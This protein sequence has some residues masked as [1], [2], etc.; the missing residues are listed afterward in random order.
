MF[1]PF[2][3]DP[4]QKVVRNLEESLVA[5]P[6]PIYV[7]YCNA[8]YVKVLSQSPYFYKIAGSKSDYAI[9]KSVIS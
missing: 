8:V 4:M 7:V 2:G 3:L 6:R 5:N 9:F 1:N